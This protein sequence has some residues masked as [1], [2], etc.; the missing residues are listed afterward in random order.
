MGDEGIITSETP[1]AE[2]FRF[3]E[4]V[5]DTR[6][7]QMVGYVEGTC[8]DATNPF[9]Y[10][11]PNGWRVSSC[12]WMPPGSHGVPAGRPVILVY[13][14]PIRNIIPPEEPGALTSI[15]Y[16]EPSDNAEIIGSAH[17]IPGING[18]Y[19]EQKNYIRYAVYGKTLEQLGYVEGEQVVSHLK[20]SPVYEDIIDVDQYGYVAELINM[21]RIGE[22]E[23]LPTQQDG[24]NPVII[25]GIVSACLLVGFGY[26]VLKKK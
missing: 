1:S 9:G 15:L 6:P 11:P 24:I 19:I 14:E 7:Y 2:S 23:K 20:T 21:R 13:C 4:I 22:P 10:V 26:Q 12:T 18:F 17:S 25:F 5:Q 8:P 3:A 16:P